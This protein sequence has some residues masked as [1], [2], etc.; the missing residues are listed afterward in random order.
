MDRRSVIPSCP[1]TELRYNVPLDTKY[2]GCY[3]NPALLLVCHSLSVS[4]HVTD[5]PPSPSV[6]LRVCVCL[7]VRKVYCGKTAEWI[8]VP[9][10]MVSGVGRGMGVLDGV[11][12]VK[13]EGAVLG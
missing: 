6:G 13:G 8:W 11:V 3:T 5:L 2:V 7:S 1:P 10:G 9:F 12:T 4:T